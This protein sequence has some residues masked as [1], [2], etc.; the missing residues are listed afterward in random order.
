MDS[1]GFIQIEAYSLA[2]VCAAAT[3]AA[4]Q[5]GSAR[6]SVRVTE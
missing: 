4:M 2:F 5:K 3:A 6:P 1:D